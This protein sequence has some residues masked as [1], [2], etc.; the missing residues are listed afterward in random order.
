ML[1]MFECSIEHDQ[2]ENKSIAIVKKRK[3]S[4]FW[5]EPFLISIV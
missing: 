2:K 4:D 3:G 5:S 1:E